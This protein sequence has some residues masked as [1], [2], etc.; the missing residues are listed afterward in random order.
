[1]PVKSSADSA[2]N[3][4][5]IISDEQVER[6]LDYMR[7]EGRGA[8]SPAPNA[9]V[10]ADLA[11]RIRSCLEQVP[12]VREERVEQARDHLAGGAPTSAEVADKMI[13]RAVSDSIR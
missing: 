3:G 13:A 12:E 1:M 11:A 5:M 6:V 2:D 4:Y 10:S 8:E 9:E 7:A